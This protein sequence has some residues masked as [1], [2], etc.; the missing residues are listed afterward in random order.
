M[1]NPYSLVFG[2]EPSQYI[3]RL[4]LTDEIINGLKEDPRK[5]YMITGVRGSG[6]TVFMTEIKSRFEKEKDFV[7][8]ELSTERNMLEAL[9]AKLAGK[10]KLSDL[11]KSAKINLSFLGFGVELKGVDPEVDIEVALEKMMQTLKKNKKKLLVFVDEVVDNAYVKEFSSVFQMLIR[12]EYPIGLLMTGLY[13]NIDDL[14]N[15]KNLTFLHRAPKMYLGPL[16]IGT[17]AANYRKNLNVDADTSIKMAQITR[18][19]SYAFQVLGY[20]MWKNGGD[21]EDA[22]ITLKQYLEEYV[23][24][25]I[26]SEISLRD[27]EILY[28]IAKTPSGKIKDIREALQLDSNSFTPYKKR[29]IRK[30]VISDERGY[31]KFALPLMQEY[32]M[33]NFY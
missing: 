5:V 17:M 15:E 18:G 26:W 23:Y 33:E 27:K 32:I 13:E 24:D 31:A 21:L 2:I 16:S 7:V 11:F 4:E 19:F 1:E 3:S 20:V 14:Q 6:K 25:K 9:V 22:I 10:D 29:L 8:V 30:G 28:T 12:D